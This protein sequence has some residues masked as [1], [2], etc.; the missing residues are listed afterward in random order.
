MYMTLGAASATKVAPDDSAGAAVP[1]LPTSGG[2]GIVSS[3]GSLTNQANI[4]WNSF[5]PVKYVV[6]GAIGLFFLYRLM[7]RKP[8]T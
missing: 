3:G 4:L 1:G 7:K 5:G 8:T 6:V 2:G